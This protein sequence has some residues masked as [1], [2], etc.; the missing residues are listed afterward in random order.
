MRRRWAATGAVAV[1]L[2]L[3][4]PGTATASVTTGTCTGT[5][6]IAGET[7]TPAN[8]SAGNPIVV[9]NEEGLVA[10]WT[11]SIADDPSSLE[12]KIQIVIAGLGIT[13]ADWGT[14]PNAQ[15]E[16]NGNYSIDDA[17]AEIEDVVP[18]GV[19]PGLYRVRG[20]HGTICE[21]FA[22]VRIEGNPLGNV[23]GWVVVVGLVLTAAGLVMAFRSKPIP[24]IEKGGN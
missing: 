4:V 23:V 1:L 5:V 6:T 18:V 21:G 15:R 3:A 20:N 7:Y 22:M 11:A 13:V 19:I 8:D 24:I 2:V 17:R 10:A 12:G 9:P 14:G 16:A